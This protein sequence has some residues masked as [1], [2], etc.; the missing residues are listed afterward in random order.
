MKN[1]HGKV[2]TT[3]TTKAGNT[4]VRY[5][6]TDV[7]KFNADTITLNNGGYETATTKKRM[8]ETS[9]LFNLGF[10]VYA[11]AGQWY[12]NTIHGELKFDNY[13]KLSFSR[14]S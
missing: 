6:S 12:A 13:G 4:V 11:K 1:L 9:N 5:H 7:V 8:N 3:V 10:Q 2:A 14:T